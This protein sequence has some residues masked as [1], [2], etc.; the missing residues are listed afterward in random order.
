MKWATTILVASVAALLALGLVMLYS[1]SMDQQG[2]RYLNKQLEWAGLGMVACC[3]AAVVDYRWLQ[4]LALPFLGLTVL[5]LIA[6]LIPGVGVERNGARRWFDFGPVHFQP[7]ELA[8]LTLLLGIA[9]YGARF[10]EKMRNFRH[11]LLMP[12]L[13]IALTCGLVFLEPDFGT[14]VLLATAA[15]IL[16]IIAGANWKHVVLPALAGAVLV[17]VAIFNDPVRL[18]RIEA[19]LHPEEHRS[20]AGWQ[21]YQSMVALGSGGVTGLGLGNSRQ[22]LGFVPEHHTDFIFSIIGEELGIIATLGI[23]LAFMAILGSGLYIAWR[24]RDR[25]GLLLGAGITFLI[26][27]QAFINIGVVTSALP[28]KGLPLPFIS[29]GGSSLLMMLTAVGILLSIAHHHDQP[30]DGS[31]SEP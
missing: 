20:G 19:F 25:F 23:I 4:K 12:G 7:S 28:N 8:K 14:T 16:L 3:V 1:A 13:G 15:I 21:A 18:K 29:Y 17:G 24:A 2:A 27:L 9:A 5:M 10:Q 26:C 30:H 6:V 11:G 22:K 31:T